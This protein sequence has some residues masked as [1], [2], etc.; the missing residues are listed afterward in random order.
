MVAK[1]EAGIKMTDKCHQLS[2]NELTHVSSSIELLT[3][4]KPRELGRDKRCP[5]ILQLL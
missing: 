4:R 1:S 5:Y 3:K 2:L